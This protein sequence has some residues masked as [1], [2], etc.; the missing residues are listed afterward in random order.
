[1]SQEEFAL[2]AGIAGGVHKCLQAVLFLVVWDIFFQ[3]ERKKRTWLPAGILVV[4]NVFLDFIPIIPGWAR[5]IICAMLILGYCRFKYR[6]CMEKAVFTLFL[7]FNFHGMSYLIASSIYQ[8]WSDITLG[9]LDVLDAGYLEQMYC[10][11]AIGQSGI[12]GVYLIVFI[13]MT[14]ILKRIVKSPPSMNLQDVVFLSVL[15]IGGS[16]LTGIVIDLS[17][18]PMEQEIFFLFTQRREMIWKIPLLAVLLFAGEI[19]AII[20]FQRYKELQS[21]K[22]KHFVEEQQMKAMKR[23]LGEAEHFYGSIR[24][25]RHEMKNHLA[26]IK[27][28]VAGEQYG[29]LETYIRKLDETIQEIDYQFST[30]NAVTDVIINDK[31]RRAQKLGITF[32]VLFAYR[33]TDTIS[34][35]DL[36]IVLDNLLDNAIEA[37][38]KVEQEKR[39]I[40]LT[41]KR[42]EHFLLVEVENSYEGRLAWKDGESVPETMKQSNLPEMLMEHGVGLKNVKDVAERYL[43]YLDIKAE[44]D[45]F[46]VTVMLQ[47]EE[48]KV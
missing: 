36:G 39:R 16:L 23:R 13:A 24:R 10:T 29:E 22:E 21:E 35:F 34:A 3:P 27:G 46:R 7:F 47:Q 38:E 4:V 25:V 11:L 40:S 8:V 17:A 32:R 37:C 5:Y 43:G 44:A 45:V 1:M 33:E 18:V 9:R 15:N 41:L 42:K 2:F 6:G 12:L 30:G 14:G 31:Y 48:R 20:I 26:N 28:L 19:S